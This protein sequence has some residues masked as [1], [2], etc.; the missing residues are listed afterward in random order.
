[1]P[2]VTFSGLGTTSRN[3]VPPPDDPGLLPSSESEGEPMSKRSLGGT[4][5]VRRRSTMT[6]CCSPDDL[7]RV[8]VFDEKEMLIWDENKESRDDEGFKEVER[9]RRMGGFVFYVLLCC[10]VLVVGRV[11][12]FWSKQRS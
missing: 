7:L 8:F 5:T 9:K 3:L 11:G 1:M 12:G 10:V 6:G 4:L 2:T